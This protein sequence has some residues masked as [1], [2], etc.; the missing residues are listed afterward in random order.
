MA[1]SPFALTSVVALKDRIAGLDGQSTGKDVELEALIITVTMA[2]ERFTR[3]K[4]VA[5]TYRATGA[6]KASIEE[7][8]KLNGDDRFSVTE[9]AFPHPPINSITSI[10]IKDAL[11]Q[12]AVTLVIASDVVF[13]PETGIVRLIDGDIWKTGMQNI[14]AVWNSGYET[15]RDERTQ[16]E[17]LC[18]DQCVHWFQLGDKSA[19]AIAS[20]SDEGG[21]VARTAVDL[22]PHVK[23]G[24]GH[25]AFPLIG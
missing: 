12:N 23:A 15:T 24:L 21:S 25:Y 2:F 13:D 17:R 3:R 4:L 22:L 7:N 19:Y 10:T 8:V 6:V 1:I 11:L 16:L 14:E 5:R 20:E 18:Q 9:F